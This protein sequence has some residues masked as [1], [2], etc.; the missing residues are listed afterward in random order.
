MGTRAAAE[1]DV[2]RTGLRT[3]YGRF[4][5]IGIRETLE[6]LIPKGYGQRRHQLATVMLH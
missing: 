4:L 6:T 3:W 5:G 1:S 2:P